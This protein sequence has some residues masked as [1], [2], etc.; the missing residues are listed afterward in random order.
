[1]TPFFPEF[2]RRKKDK[3]TS[4]PL[5]PDELNSN[6]Q[7]EEQ[8]PLKR[9]DEEFNLHFEQPSEEP[10]VFLSVF[11]LKDIGPAVVTA[12]NET[13]R[14]VHGPDYLSV[15]FELT[16]QPKP[17]TKSADE[18]ITGD[19]HHGLILIAKK[20]SGMTFVAHERKDADGRVFFDSWYDI[21]GKNREEIL[22][23]TKSG[24]KSQPLTIPIQDLTTTKFQFTRRA[25]IE[26]IAEN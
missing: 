21:T 12:T 7:E 2:L 11:N 15:V 4:Q 9:M 1:M 18:P 13:A 5:Q 23:A 25:G 22:Q 14:L 3:Y 24:K 8:T 26:G 20:P 6:S 19:G 17:Q 10:K 16:D